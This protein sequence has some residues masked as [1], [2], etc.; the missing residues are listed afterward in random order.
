MA[1]SHLVIINSHKPG[2][3][4]K[5]YL[6]ASNHVM[7]LSRTS[8]FGFRSQQHLRGW[9]YAITT[10]YGCEC[11]WFVHCTNHICTNFSLDTLKINMATFAAFL[12]PRHVNERSLDIVVNHYEKY[13]IRLGQ[14]VTLPCV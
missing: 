1:L 3:T 4:S 7:Q 10:G 5:Q 13:R 2:L 6:H 9:W 8:V 11:S 12:L 14:V